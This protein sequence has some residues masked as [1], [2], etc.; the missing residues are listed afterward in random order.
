MKKITVWL[1]KVA[2]SSYEMFTCMEDFNRENNLG[3]NIIK[4]LVINHLTSLKTHFE[5]YFIPELDTSEFHWVQN[6]CDVVI[7]K[8]SHLSLK[9]QEEFLELSSDFNL[10]VNFSKKSLS[11][12]WVSVKTEYPLLS[13]LAMLA[14]LP[15]ASAYL[16]EKSFSTLTY[17]KTKYRSNLK[18]LEPV[19]RP[20]ITEI[21][22]R[23]DLLCENMQAPQ[24]H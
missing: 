15:F 19:L 8:V 10:K 24:S 22:P 16:C 2:S 5:K 12:F 11:S 4:S 1:H 13:E 18:D 6:P 14:L 20:A 23:F 7:E 17:V 3:L 9:A 21:E